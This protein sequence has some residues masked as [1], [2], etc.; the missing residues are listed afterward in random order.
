MLMNVD[1][2]FGVIIV[3]SGIVGMFFGGGVVDKLG[4]STATVLCMFVI[5]VVG[6]F[7]CFEFVFRC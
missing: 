2:F 3:V 5:V 4:S 1:M 7:V 6:G